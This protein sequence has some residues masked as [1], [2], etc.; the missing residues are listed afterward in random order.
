[1]KK[2]RFALLGV[3]AYAAAGAG[4]PKFHYVKDAELAFV[5]E[6]ATDP[7]CITRNRVQSRAVLTGLIGDLSAELRHVTWRKWKRSDDG[8]KVFSDLKHEG[9]WSDEWRDNPEYYGLNYRKLACSYVDL[10]KDDQRCIDR[11]CRNK[12]RAKV[13][14]LDP[15]AIRV[16]ASTL[17]EAE[18]FFDC[19]SDDLEPFLELL[20]RDLGLRDY[21]LRL[22]LQ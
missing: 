20:R 3:L 17:T 7:D 19:E 14:E 21:M 16:Y 2:L 18:D 10:S 13:R 8:D 5:F 1:M 22:L 9:F 4:Q 15:R 6:C 12:V 11:N